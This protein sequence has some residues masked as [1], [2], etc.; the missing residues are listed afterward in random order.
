MVLLTFHQR[1][2]FKKEG[3]QC[4]FP[5]NTQIYNIANGTLCFQTVNYGMCGDGL[6]CEKVA[7]DCSPGICREKTTGKNRCIA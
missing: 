6:E 3:E 2:D 4:G 7:K 1:L 5:P